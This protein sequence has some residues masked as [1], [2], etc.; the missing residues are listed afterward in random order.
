MRTQNSG[1]LIGGSWFRSQ[2]AKEE[3]LLQRKK[4]GVASDAGLQPRGKF[5]DLE[6][7][8]SIEVLVPSHDGMKVPLSI[9]H[10]KDLPRDGKRP[11]LVTGYGGYGF[12]LHAAF[13]PTNLAWLER[14]GVLAVAHV[15]GGGEYGE[16]WRLAGQ[17]QNKQNTWKDF[18]AC[19][20]YLLRERYTSP[21][22][23][24]GEGTSAG[25]ILIGRAITERPDLFA[26]AL[27]NVGCLDMLRAETTTNGVPNIPEFGTVTTKDGFDGLL[28]M[29]AYH[30]VKDGVRYPAVLLTHGINDPRVEPWH[31]A[32]MTARLQ[33]ATAS[34]KPVLFRL[35]YHAGHGIG[36]TK[37]QQQEELADQWTFLLWQ[38]GEPGFQPEE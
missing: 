31:S 29:S 37:R 24:A 8:E 30:Q 35:D 6:G 25:G 21:E 3:S 19:C 7:F 4:T 15:R 12:S 20:E 11:T 26:A 2:S 32:K 28:A 18:I 36:S 38:M 16:Q 34:G 23:L 14:G 22:K 10:K 1:N 33:A 27:I 17:K 5:D 13:D 9:I